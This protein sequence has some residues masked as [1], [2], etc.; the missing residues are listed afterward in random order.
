MTIADYANSFHRKENI[1]IHPLPLF[2]PPPSIPNF[3]FFL[4]NNEI[5]ISFRMLEYYTSCFIIFLK[6][7][8]PRLH[9]YITVL[10]LGNRYIHLNNTL[11][12]YQ[13]KKKKLNRIIISSKLILLKKK[14]EASKPTDHFIACMLS[15]YLTDD[16]LLHTQ[17][18][19]SD[20]KER[21]GRLVLYRDGADCC[22]YPHY[23]PHNHRDS[24][25]SAGQDLIHCELVAR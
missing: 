24:W 25:P 12:I 18:F 2:S 14:S 6:N 22:I 3:I 16:S 10:N 21:K 1:N 15:S 9:T 11:C 13:H 19:N 20:C 8:N 17:A 23:K 7:I 5:K 4:L